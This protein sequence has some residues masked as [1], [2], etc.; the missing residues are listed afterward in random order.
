[1]SWSPQMEEACEVLAKS[2]EYEGDEILVTAARL[3]RIAINAAEVSRR[4]SDNPTTAKHALLVIEPLKLSLGTLKS[5]ITPGHLH[6]SKILP[7]LI[8]PILKALQ[9][10]LLGSCTALRSPSMSSRSYNLRLRPIPHLCTNNPCSSQSAS[11][12]SQPV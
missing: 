2:Q 1:M 5:T 11:N 10:L 8:H 12:I 9:A 7:Y 4:V 6:H 3:A